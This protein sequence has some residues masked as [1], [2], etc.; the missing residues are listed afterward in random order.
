MMIDAAEFERTLKQSMHETG[1]SVDPTKDMSPEDAAE[2]KRQN[3]KH[4]DKFKTASE[5]YLLPTAEAA[6][7][8][9]AKVLGWKVTKNLPYEGGYYGQ[10]QSEDTSE[11]SLRVEFEEMHRKA[12][13]L[14]DVPSEDV[15]VVPHV[16]LN[17]STI[18]NRLAD[19]VFSSLKFKGSPDQAMRLLRT[20][21]QV[22]HAAW[23]EGTQ[24]KAAQ[25][26]MFDE[27]ESFSSKVSFAIESGLTRLGMVLANH[28]LYGTHVSPQR[29]VDRPFISGS[30]YVTGLTP[31]NKDQAAAARK[32]MTAVSRKLSNDK[33]TFNLNQP[34]RWSQNE[35]AFGYEIKF[36]GL[37]RSASANGVSIADYEAELGKESKFERG[38]DVSLD[39][40]PTELQENVENPPPAVT[41][42]REEME[43]KSATDKEAKIQARQI[44]ILK[45][46]VEGAGAG[47]A[48]DY[49]D[50]PQ[51]VQSALIRVKD[52]EVLW[53]DVNR[54]LSDNTKRAAESRT[55]ATGLY[56]FTKEAE[57]VCGSASNKL[58]KF[59]GKLAKEI[60]EKDAETPAFLEEHTARTASKAARMLRGCMAEI[61]PGQP[62]KTA[63]KGE[64]GRY[65]FSAK[66]ARLA[67]EACNTV[68]HEA[69]VI[70]SDLH[71]RMGSKHA[72]ITGFL[73]KHAK[74]A[75]CG[76]SD[77]ILE[78]YPAQEQQVIASETTEK[79]AS[80]LSG[81]SIHPSV[82][83]ILTW[84]GQGTPREAASFLASDD[85][86]G[87]LAGRT[88][89]G[90]KS[91]PDDAAPYN[92]HP[93]SPP[94]GADGSTERKR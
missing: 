62:T 5:S 4:K 27:L 59:A 23:I 67:L 33:Y 29:E 37:D 11:F 47:A 86:E 84:E 78:A 17:T 48:T 80:D 68:E 90:D 49:D 43:S 83:Q 50:L 52:S 18:P 61:G 24:S 79:T 30:M 66:T 35:L 45:K 81:Y 46:Y 73:N 34:A 91:K 85:E 77:L 40:L 94:A 70:A 8:G 82:D 21:P 6:V 22:A 58:A 28:K 31:G 55:A 32:V 71:S 19:R 65:G 44:A 60:Y 74:R 93:E 92:I 56:G 7:H 9:I 75:K 64:K 3:E 57:K 20:A 12:L 63:A 53:S 25:D 36:A 41:K 26:A 15:V 13:G 14:S 39:E 1:V 87:P 16:F 76:W 54:W 2:W 88:W 89:D 51:E 42:L 72:S 69:G 38:E 10:V